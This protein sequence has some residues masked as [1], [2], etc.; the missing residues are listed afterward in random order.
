MM[1]AFDKKKWAFVS[2]FARRDVIH[3]YGG[4]Y[5]DMDVE[6]VSPLAPYLRA[7]SF[8]CRQDDGMLELGS[9]FGAQK[10]NRLS[11]EM[12]NGYND[13]HYVLPDGS[14]DKTA[15]PELLNPVIQ[16]NGIV[17]GHDSEIV[18][19]TLVLSNDYITC[20]SN[21]ASVRNAKLG[22]HWHN[23]S[24]LDEKDRKNLSKSMAAREPLIRKFFT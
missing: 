3:S 19:E 14:V 20:F 24:W 21:D 4:V 13:R 9:G 1:E 16:K 10:G 5:L 7:D 18:G 6:L 2:D 8:F 11:G 22:I 15:Q 12:R 23:G 17:R